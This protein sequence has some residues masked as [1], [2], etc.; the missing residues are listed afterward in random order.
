MVNLDTQNFK[1]LIIIQ[2]NTG[3]KNKSEE[4][5]GDAKRLTLQRPGKAGKSVEV[6]QWASVI[7]CTTVYKLLLQVI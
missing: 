6:F 3:V 1:R 4:R 5:G 7:F 2:R